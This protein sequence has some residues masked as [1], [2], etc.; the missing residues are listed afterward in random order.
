MKPRSI[1]WGLQCCWGK[2]DS[3]CVEVFMTGAVYT[4]RREKKGGA[5]AA[6][7]G[8]CVVV[9]LT[10]E[11]K[12]SPRCI[13]PR[14][15]EINV[16]LVFVW[17]RAARV[18]ENFLCGYTLDRREQKGARGGRRRLSDSC[19]CPAKPLSSHPSANSIT[20]VCG[21]TSK[22]FLAPNQQLL[23]AASPIKNNYFSVLSFV[24]FN[25]HAQKILNC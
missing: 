2:V 14:A 9:S 12:F 8:L 15:S 13:A 7:S 18:S 3:G 5:R 23:S 11:S 20:H 19:C 1:I 4:R 16:P 21:L 6:K 10:F 24:L 17:A 25:K 22:S